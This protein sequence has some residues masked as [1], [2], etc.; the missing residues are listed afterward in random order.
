MQ[1]LNRLWIKTWIRMFA[2]ASD[3]LERPDLHGAILK[4]TERATRLNDREGP[5]EA[6]R[7]FIDAYPDAEATPQLLVELGDYH[8]DYLDSLDSGLDAFEEVTTRFST[9]KW[10]PVA[11]LKRCM[12]LLEA[13]RTELAYESADNFL[14]A[15]PGSANVPQA[16]YLRALCE[17]A[18]GLDETALAA[19]RALSDDYPDSDSAAQA[20][21]WIGSHH[22]ARQNYQ[23]GKATFE[24]L[25]Q[26]FPDGRLAPKVRTYTK[27]LESQ[28]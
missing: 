28:L 11:E 15:Y 20:L 12:A 14:K 16:K 25:L 5:V 22:I 1:D 19:M 13:K 2:F 17:G 6:F 27:Q 4:F 9:S 24:E 18:L 23:E 10:A 3:Q 26:R 7:L 21:F 8:V